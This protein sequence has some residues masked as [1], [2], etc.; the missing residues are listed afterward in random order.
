MRVRD[1]RATVT[2]TTIARKSGTL[3][4]QTLPINGTH[5]PE[6]ELSIAELCV[7]DGHRTLH[8][9]NGGTG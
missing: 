7:Y 4:P 9:A 2:G 8:R 1:G 3:P 6:E 5:D